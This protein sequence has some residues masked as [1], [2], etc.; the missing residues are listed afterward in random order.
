MLFIPELL[1]TL[2]FSCSY[3]C[4]IGILNYLGLD[5]GEISNKDIEVQCSIEGGAC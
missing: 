3:T 1:V 4:S 5:Y 2:I